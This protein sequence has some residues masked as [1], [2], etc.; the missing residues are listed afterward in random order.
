MDY[1]ILIIYIY[2]FVMLYGYVYSKK[3]IYN[4]LPLIKSVYVVNLVLFIVNRFTYIPGIS[5]IK[6]LIIIIEIINLIL[7]SYLLFT[8]REKEGKIKHLKI[9]FCA[10]LALVLYNIIR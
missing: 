9:V 4:N 7:T 3:D 10:L 6:I 5:K 2:M 1:I 8:A